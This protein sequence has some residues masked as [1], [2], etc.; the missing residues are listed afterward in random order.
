MSVAVN[1]EKFAKCVGKMGRYLCCCWSK[2]RQDKWKQMGKGGGICDCPQIALTQS[3]LCGKR[4]WKSGTMPPGHRVC[5][6]LQ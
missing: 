5:R 4:N 6:K 3:S 2:L 1:S